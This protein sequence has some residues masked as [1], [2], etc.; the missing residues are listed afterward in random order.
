MSEHR[1]ARRSRSSRA[2]GVGRPVLALLASGLVLGV[3]AAVTLAAWND[4][5]FVN[6]TF[7]AGVFVFEGSSTN[8]TTFAEHPTIGTAAALD[9]QVAPDNL[10]PG[11]VVYA[12]FAVRLGANTSRD[13][14]VDLLSAGTSGTL[15]GLTYQVI[16][17]TSWG[18]NASTTGTEIVPAGTALTDLPTAAQISIAHGSGSTPGTPAYLCFIVT[19]SSGL[20]Q[21]STGTITWELVAQSV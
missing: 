9:F 5:E 19:A 1:I 8:G 6:G 17:P 4:T 2:R 3:G 11:S 20:V 21:G 10:A 7:A 18:C 14:T 16:Q 13:A 12:P 15:T